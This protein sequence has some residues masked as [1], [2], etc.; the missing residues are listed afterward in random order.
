V[1]RA[2]IGLGVGVTGLALAVA[3]GPRIGVQVAAGE[4]VTVESAGWC[5][6]GLCLHGVRAPALHG[7]EAKHVAVDWDRGVRLVGVSVEVGEG[8][9]GGTATG[10]GGALPSALGWVTQV[11]VEDL[12]VV[13]T[14]LPPLSGEVYPA[15][16][17][18]GQDV[19][20]DGDVAEATMQTPY[21]RL[22][23]RVEPRDG[24]LQVD[25]EV[26]RLSVPE[27]ML[28]QAF[29]LVG[30]R[31]AGRYADGTWTGVVTVGAGEPGAGVSVPAEIDV[32]ARRATARFE[33]V[34]I[35]AVYG[36][37]GD[38]VPEIAT[39]NVRGT[40]DGVV[41]V[42]AAPGGDGALGA[43]AISVE[44]PELEGFRVEGIA[45]ADLGDSF[46]YPVEGAD[47][48]PSRRTAGRGEP[49]WLAL[50]SIGPTLPAAVIAAEDASFYAHPGYDLQSMVDAAT[51]NAERGGVHRGGSTLTQQLAKNLF[52][53]GSRTYVRK[54]R[55]L[56][57]AVELERDLGK[58]GILETYLNVVE[59]GPGVY[60]AGAA[61]DR[62][63][64]KAPA[65]LLPE[66]A[67]WLA[68]I[69]PSPTSAWTQQ[70]QRDRPNM[71]KVRAILDNMVMLPR[72]DREAAKARTLHF[73]R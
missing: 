49:G 34:P 19:T 33:R 68:S 57:Y 41:V 50:P 58:A 15:R 47:G 21:G 63:F 14:P 73:V 5:G 24:G 44:R 67:A 26:P 23:G 9:A 60:G 40:L 51:D 37:L 55:E 2:W 69:L 66:E 29:D 17:L 61:A 59:F 54:L 6:T 31:A 38:V 13:G 8:G 7:L 39:A 4:G 52:L 64:L 62:Y 28:G 12:V 1:K 70:Y 32:H 53:D 48:R 36:A 3:A 46:S 20:V 71:V 22:N 10:G 18:H 45:G 43:L 27:S 35:A 30:V 16:R 72:D 65:G 42:Q 11:T 25:V 56:L